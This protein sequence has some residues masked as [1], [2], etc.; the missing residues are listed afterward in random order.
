MKMGLRVYG[1]IQFLTVK[2][3]DV[4]LPETKEKRKINHLSGTG[5]A[6]LSEQ[7]WLQWL[8]K[9]LPYLPMNV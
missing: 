2:Q 3:D 5:T 7:L 8:K 1:G 6:A 9:E 4:C